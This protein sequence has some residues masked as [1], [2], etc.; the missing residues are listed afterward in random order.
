MTTP[1]PLTPPGSF[2]LSRI[3]GLLGMAVAAGQAFT[4][5]GS[6]YTHAFVVVDGGSVVQAMPSG[7]ELAPLADFVGRDDVRWCDA[8]VQSTLAFYREALLT[9]MTDLEM[10]D[11]LADTYERN[12]RQA[13]SAEARQL[14]G[15]GYSFADY[16]A[17]G[18]AHLGV[19]PHWLR[20][21]IAASGRLICSQLVD[22]TYRRQGV[23]LFDDGRLPMDVTPGDLDAYRVTHL[24][25]LAASR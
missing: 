10:V 9:R 20:R 25:Q 5:D 19:R 7:A 16:L 12:L 8:P 23:H 6:R 2:G 15:T 11:R 22:E 17:L 3:G 18:L 24:E 1:T 14:V 21:Y 13:L 4:F